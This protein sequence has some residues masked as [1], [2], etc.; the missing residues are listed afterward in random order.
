MT[1][2][3][4]SVKEFEAAETQVAF[5]AGQKKDGLLGAGGYFEKHPLPFPYLL[6]Q[7]RDVVK[8]YGVYKP[9]GIDGINVAQPSTFLVDASGSIRWIYV[10]RS[11]FDRPDPEDVL[12]QVAGLAS[13]SR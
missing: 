3:G 11:Q 12:K 6:D 7:P 2:Y 9:I 13:E 1:R 8:A 4:S 10:G 5:V